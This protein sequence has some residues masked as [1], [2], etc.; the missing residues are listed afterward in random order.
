MRRLNKTFRRSY[1]PSITD[2]K[3]KK[4]RKIRNTNIIIQDLDHLDVHKM[5]SEI[6]RKDDHDQVLLQ[7]MQQSQRFLTEKRD[8]KQTKSENDLTY[9]DPNKQQI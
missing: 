9:F 7:K 8:I 2:L 3:W 4:E 6:G 5:K 1:N